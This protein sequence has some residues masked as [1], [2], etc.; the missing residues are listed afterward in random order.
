MKRKTTALLLSGL[1][2]PGLGQ[3][4]LGR[5]IAGIALIMAMNLL[6]L[7]ALFVLLRGASPLIAAKVTSGNL[8]AAEITTALGGVAGFG[9]ALLAGF[10]FLWSFAVVD[11]LKNGE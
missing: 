2:L 11:I 1:I 5:K 4:F 3:L 7:L 8:S 9:K 10:F 6:L